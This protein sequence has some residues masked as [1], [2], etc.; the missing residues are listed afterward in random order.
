MSKLNWQVSLRES[1]RPKSES[2]SKP[3]NRDKIKQRRRKKERPSW[4]DTVSD[5]DALKPSPQEL[6][7][8]H[9]LHQPKKEHERVFLQRALE[10]SK[11]AQEQARLED[12]ENKLNTTLSANINKKRAMI[13]ESFN[14]QERELRSVLEE[15]DKT[16]HDVKDLFGDNPMKHQAIPSITAAPKMSEDLNNF[17]STLDPHKT[18]FYEQLSQSVVQQ[19]ELNAISDEE[20]E[21]DVSNIGSYTANE[22]SASL[23]HTN[24]HTFQSNFDL[25]QYKPSAAHFVA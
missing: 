6:R 14:H 2:L 19:P 10:F 22:A 4:N 5:L 17:F 12:K 15:S 21:D 3:N 23:E 8:N 24:K 16:F 1:S 25:D 9:E 20:E 13:R 11:L 7:R 18:T